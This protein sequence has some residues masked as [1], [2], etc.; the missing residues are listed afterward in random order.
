MLCLCKRRHQKGMAARM[1]LARCDS[2]RRAAPGA[3]RNVATV[4]GINVDKAA[5]LRGQQ[6]DIVEHRQTT[7]ELW[8]EF[9]AMFPSVVNGEAVEIT[10]AEVVHGADSGADFEPPPEPQANAASAPQV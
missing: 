1:L 7:A 6:T 10:D 8:A 5:L 4:K 3:I 2:G 9:A